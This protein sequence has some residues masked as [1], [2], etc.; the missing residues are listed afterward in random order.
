[1]EESKFDL[2]LATATD[3]I[4]LIEGYSDFLTAELLL[5]AIDIG[6]GAIRA[7]YQEV[8]FFVNKSRKNKMN[9]AIRV[10]PPKYYKQIEEFFES[11]LIEALQIKS[12]MPQMEDISSLGTRVLTVLAKDGYMKEDDI[13]KFDEAV[14]IDE[15]DEFMVADGEVDEGWKEK[16]WASCNN[17]MKM[18]HGW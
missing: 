15:E 3:A 2:L 18:L 17:D 11:G 9:E 1:M 7:I 5:Q 14:E 12:K 8:E 10:P 13:I 4:L 6:Q 16:Q